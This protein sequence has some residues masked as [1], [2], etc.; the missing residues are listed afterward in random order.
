MRALVIGAGISGI[1]MGIR[2]KRAGIDDFRILEQANGLG[3]T[4]RVNTYPGAAVDIASLIFQFGFHTHPWRRTHARQDE[5]LEYLDQV[6]SDAGLEPHLVFDTRV[7]EVRWDEERHQW[8]VTTSTSEVYVA[9][10]LVSAVGLLSNPNHAAWPGLDRFRGPVM[11]TQ[12]WRHDVELSDARVAV[13]GVGSSSAQIVPAIAPTARSV[14]VF[15]RDPG[16][17][18]PKGERVFDENELRRGSRRWARRLDRTVQIVRKEWRNLTGRPSYV[19][20][21]RRNQQM[22]Q[23]ARGYIDTVF[24]DRPE[25]RAAVTPTYPF[26]G[27]R[28]VLSDDFYPALRRD[29]VRLVA[30]PVASATPTGLVDVDG[31]HHEVDVIVTATGFTASEFL[32]GYDVIGRRGRRLRDTWA[33]GAFAHVGMTVPGYPNFYLLF[34]P[35]TN[36]SG[37]VSIYWKAEQQAAWVVADLRRMRRRGLTA[38]DT[39]E[40]ACTAY[41][42]WL[43]RRLRRTVWAQAS[44]YFKH[45][46]G[47]IVTQF[48]GSI[49]LQW[50]L[51]KLGRPFGT[52]GLTRKE[53]A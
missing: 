46:S 24:A 48:D 8:Q 51:L 42:A 41:N 12:Q 35:N 52:Y 53:N 43:Q 1:A 17:V 22:E 6:A 50:L 11:H 20:G 40:L 30:R 4:W 23:L 7:T 16:W 31:E 28:V 38:I 36:G 27:K 37:A 5:V 10:V 34:G 13:V 21:S 49:T 47:R 15:Q 32:A 26:E 25:L 19:A 44:N 14:T 2:L 33:E 3:G 39:H 29:D 18:L 45:P 9:D